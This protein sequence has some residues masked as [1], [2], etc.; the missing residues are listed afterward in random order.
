MLRGRPVQTFPNR[1]PLLPHC[2]L[3]SRCKKRGKNSGITVCSFKPLKCFGEYGVF[4][5]EPWSATLYCS[6]KVATW[7]CKQEDFVRHLK[8]LPT[9]VRCSPVRTTNRYCCR[10]A[11][12]AIA[13]HTAKCSFNPIFCGF[14]L[15]VLGTPRFCF[16]FI[17][18]CHVARLDL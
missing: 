10:V 4:T 13:A 2:L 7:A 17:S 15:E 8:M 6:T 5:D 3:S 9:E 11:V 18:D 16:V 1:S 12:I 14:S